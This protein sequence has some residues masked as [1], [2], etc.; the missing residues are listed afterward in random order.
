MAYLH[1]QL[2]VAA[3]A[4]VL[5]LFTFSWFLAGHME[6]VSGHSWIALLTLVMLLVV[7]ATTCFRFRHQPSMRTWLV[8]HVF[9]NCLLAIGLFAVWHYDRAIFYYVAIFAGAFLMR[10]W[11]TWKLR[12]AVLKN[13]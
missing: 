6:Y 8:P 4:C 11:G 10:T 9:G 1:R 2:A 7:T 12:G 5:L 3:I 13:K